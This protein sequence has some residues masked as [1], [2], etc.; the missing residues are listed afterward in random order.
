MWKKKK[1][2]REEK[3]NSFAILL[4]TVIIGMVGFSYASVPLYRLFCQATG[5]GGT[6][7]VAESVQKPREMSKEERILTIRFNADVSDSI[8]WRFQPAQ[9]EMKVRVGE[10][11]L[12][13]YRAYNP[14]NESIVGISTYN[15][16]PQKAGIFF[17]KIQCFC[18]E[19]QRLQ[20]KELVEMP[21]FFFID[22]EML[23]DETMDDVNIITLSY[24]FFPVNHALAK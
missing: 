21:V 14:T 13:F 2:S 8:P 6:T 24:T 3:R 7:Q 15:V 16:T 11:A 23:E 9:Q 4:I 10:T 20:P 18:F 12:A 17:N 1:D 5:F 22:A 19:E